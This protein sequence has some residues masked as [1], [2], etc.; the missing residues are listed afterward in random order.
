MSS[1]LFPLYPP[2]LTPE[3]QTHLVSTTKEWCI[4]HGLAIRPSQSHQKDGD[5]PNG[6]LAVAAPV[7]LFP[8]LFPLNCF[9]E[10]LMIQ[11]AY[12]E[13]Y[14][15]IARDEEWL[16]EVVSELAMIDD[17]IANL[18][19][20]HLNVKEEGYAQLED[21]IACLESNQ[22][23]DLSLGLF[24]SDYMIHAPANTPPSLKQIE[25]NT[26]ASSFGALAS[27]TSSL[28]RFLLTTAAYSP[29]AAHYI[30]PDYLPSN[31]SIE[32]LAGGLAAAHQAY[33]QLKNNQGVRMLCVVF[34]TQDGERNV[35]DQ[36]HI[37][38]AL[39][40]HHRIKVF[41]V[42]FDAVL[43]QTRVADDGSRALL[44][45][46]P[47]FPERSYEVTTV[48]LRAGYSPSEYNLP[49]A[50]TARLHLER[51]AAIKCPSVLTHLAG[52]K[53][54]QQILATPDSPHLMR[55]LPYQGIAERVRRTF[56]PM[57]PLDNSAVGSEGR[58]LAME[59]NERFVM[60]PQREGGGN[61]VYRHK[62]KEVLE[63][64]SEEEW[65]KYVLMEMVETPAQRNVI[66]RNGEVQEG[67]VICELGMFGT[68]LWRNKPM[69]GSVPRSRTEPNT[70]NAA[71]R[72]ADEYGNAVENPSKKAKL[73]TVDPSEVGIIENEEAGFLL[74]TKGDTSEEGGVAAGFGA[75][76]SVCL[77]DV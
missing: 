19:N 2:Q 62:I 64:T 39:F 61:N 57:Y 38:Y 54:V 23:Q 7:T 27:R 45:S 24:R 36:K 3:Q 6:H 70:A 13:L 77:I 68:C 25:F 41:R 22:E 63:Q 12:N 34:I 20:V 32:K 73:S 59:G 76:D 37:E 31:P 65:A 28:H 33:G 56:M 43:E 15:N 1:P 60:K 16:G 69:N 8:S 21:D 4:A 71:E 40:S 48:Y 47:A 74:R 35:F 46:P 5:D 10:A 58:R 11:T 42:P 52:T 53:K 75:I 14:A 55:F 72:D 17:Y 44:Y 51:S 49:S 67:G 18:W 26:I 66:M 30:R 9:H 50:W 29:A